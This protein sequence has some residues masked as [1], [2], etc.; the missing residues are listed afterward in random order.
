CG[1]PG[2]SRS[3]RHGDQH[4]PGQHLNATICSRRSRN[5]TTLW[6]ELPWTSDQAVWRGDWQLAQGCN[7]W[8]SAWSA[9]GSSGQQSWC[10]NLA[11]R[12]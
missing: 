3:D 7:C 12:H 10:R 11:Q 9:Q 2:T 1:C 5:E 6:I 8:W 4:G